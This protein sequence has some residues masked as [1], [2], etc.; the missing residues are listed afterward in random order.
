MLN[1]KAQTHKIE[2]KFTISTLLWFI[3]A[4]LAILAI[5]FL[6]KKLTGL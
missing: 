3:F 1:K 5:Y 6:V 4:I 2:T